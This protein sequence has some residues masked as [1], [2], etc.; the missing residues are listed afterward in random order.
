M[1]G[2]LMRF[3]GQRG[4]RAGQTAFNFLYHPKFCLHPDVFRRGG[5]EEWSPPGE[6]TQNALKPST[7][8]A[9]HFCAQHF[10]SYGTLPYQLEMEGFRHGSIVRS[11]RSF[12]SDSSLDDLPHE[13]LHEDPKLSHVNSAGRAQMVD[14]SRKEKTTRVAK[15]SATVLLGPLAFALVSSNAG[16]KGDVLSVAQLAGINAAKQT[17]FLIPLC[18]PIMLTA[19]D[20]QLS[21]HAESHAVKICTEAK[22]TGPTGVEMEALTAA[23]VAA[24]T[25]YDMC[26]AVEKGIEIH[27][28]QLEAK[29]GGKSGDWRR[30]SGEP[31]MKAT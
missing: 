9:Q 21:L 13:S 25:V 19:V 30:D 1:A 31:T 24:L 27:G 7:L 10:C 17:G 16:A 29:S 15:A 8:G 3:N 4:V 20:V 28:I 2:R 5:P 11:S 22:A 23:A 18:H 6:Q 26:K 12:S 14:V